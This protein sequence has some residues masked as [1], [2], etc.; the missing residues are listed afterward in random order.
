MA[1]D[2]SIE[3]ALLLERWQGIVLDGSSRGSALCAD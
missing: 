2:L 1:V 3:T